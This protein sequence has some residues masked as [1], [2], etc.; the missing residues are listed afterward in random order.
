LI[1]INFGKGKIGKF[2][3]ARILSVLIP[4]LISFNKYLKEFRGNIEIEN[5]IT[6]K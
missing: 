3:L 5:K 4:A 1:I 6:F 2:K